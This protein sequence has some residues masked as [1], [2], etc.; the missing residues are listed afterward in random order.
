MFQISRA[1]RKRPFP[2]N[3]RVGRDLR[4]QSDLVLNAGSIADCCLACL[5]S[6]S[7]GQLRAL[8]H[9]EIPPF[10]QAQSVGSDLALIAIE[11][12]LPFLAF[13]MSEDSRRLPLILLF[14][15]LNMVH[16]FHHSSEGFHSLLH[17]GTYS[18]NMVNFVHLVLDCGAQKQTKVQFSQEPTLIQ[19]SA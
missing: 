11:N 1:A 4:D 9:Q 7:E 2:W 8:C 16:C 6:S 14:C 15:K 13:Q 18:L 10:P 3:H 5:K 17:C 19:V 12:S